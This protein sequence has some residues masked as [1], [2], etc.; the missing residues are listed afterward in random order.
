MAGEVN[1]QNIEKCT[2]QDNKSN[3]TESAMNK[4]YRRQRINE[5]EF[6]RERDA[7]K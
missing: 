3:V 6:G 5:Q 4:S 2:Y 7:V 1:I